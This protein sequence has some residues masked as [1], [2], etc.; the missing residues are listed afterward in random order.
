VLPTENRA[1]PVKVPAPCSLPPYYSTRFLH[2]RLPPT[3]CV[4]PES[5]L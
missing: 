3:S 5:C 4:S 1:S 2:S